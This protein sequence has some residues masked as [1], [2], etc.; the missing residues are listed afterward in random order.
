MR[1]QGQ[2]L[3]VAKEKAKRLLGIPALIKIKGARGKVEVV[4]GQISALFPAVFT[5]TID[6][7]P[8]RTF[9]YADI[10]TGNIL[11]LNPKKT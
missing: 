5:I 11:F 8:S 2:D 10:L 7:A 3:T 9:S 4:S 6:G 1:E